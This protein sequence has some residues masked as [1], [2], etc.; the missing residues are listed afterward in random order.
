MEGVRRDGKI[1]GRVPPDHSVGHYF[2]KQRFCL[3]RYVSH[4]YTILG[5]PHILGG[6][7]ILCAFLNDLH[8][9][10]CMEVRWHARQYGVC[11]CSLTRIHCAHARTHIQR[12]KPSL[13]FVKNACHPLLSWTTG[14]MCVSLICVYHCLHVRI[15]AYQEI[16]LDGLGF[17]FTPVARSTLDPNSEKIFT[18]EFS[19]TDQSVR[20]E[21]V[22]LMSYW[23]YCVDVDSIRLCPTSP[24]Y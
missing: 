15:F 12:F 13:C 23:H 20:W 16:R 22:L 9:T 7:M 19:E 6:I 2:L 11:V 14:D 24:N 1:G 17:W 18:D 21:S 3:G 5:A 10:Y 8:E 4:M